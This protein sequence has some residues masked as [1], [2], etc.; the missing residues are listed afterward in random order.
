MQKALPMLLAAT[1][2]GSDGSPRAE[3][4]NRG[5]ALRHLLSNACAEK[6]IFK[7]NYH[8][9]LR[10]LNFRLNSANSVKHLDFS[11]DLRQNYCHESASHIGKKHSDS[12]W[13]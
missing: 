1:S 7:S 11:D 6:E 13:A 8:V 2:S 3:N 10:Q 4:V 12:A 9:T 5:S